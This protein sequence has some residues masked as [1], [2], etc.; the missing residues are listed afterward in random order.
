[1]LNMPSICSPGGVR[2]SRARAPAKRQR[3]GRSFT[4]PHNQLRLVVLSGLVVLTGLPFAVLSEDGK[5]PQIKNSIG[6]KFVLI[7]QGKFTMG[8][9]LIFTGAVRISEMKVTTSGRPEASR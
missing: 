7:P 6:M 5:D 1:M 2:N 8:S 9:P 3:V 4:L